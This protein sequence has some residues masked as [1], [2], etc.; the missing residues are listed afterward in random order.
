MH[1]QGWPQLCC[2]CRCDQ[3]EQN[4]IGPNREELRSKTLTTR[5]LALR[6][7]G[8]GFRRLNPDPIIRNSS[9]APFLGQ[10]IACACMQAC[11]AAFSDLPDEGS[12]PK[13]VAAGKTTAVPASLSWLETPFMLTLHERMCQAEGFQREGASQGTVKHTSKHGPPEH[14]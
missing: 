2:K 11:F 6:I 1:A 4:R 7:I 10:L 14:S 3:R 9:S 13:P 5:T 8:S 12:G